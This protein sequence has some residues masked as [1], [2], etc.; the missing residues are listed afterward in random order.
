ML[1]LFYINGI[2]LYTKIFKNN[3]GKDTRIYIYIY[4]IL[5]DAEYVTVCVGHYVYR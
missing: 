1:D 5:F 3:A 4:I 2:Y